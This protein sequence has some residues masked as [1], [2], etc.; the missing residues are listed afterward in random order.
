MYIFS[1]LFMIVLRIVVPFSEHAYLTWFYLYAIVQTFLI[2]RQAT[3][4]KLDKSV[5]VVV[6]VGLWWVHSDHM[7]FLILYSILHIDPVIHTDRVL[8][9]KNAYLGNYRQLFRRIDTL[10]FFMFWPV[11]LSY[12]F[13]NPCCMDIVIIPISF[14]YQVNVANN[15]LNNK[16]NV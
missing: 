5:S 3:I 6:C 14:Y 9:G 1:V 7:E 13:L 12:F 2:T 16:K 10:L 8:F 15:P 11:A 4:S